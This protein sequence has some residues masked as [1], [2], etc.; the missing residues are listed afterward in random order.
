MVSSD[1]VANLALIFLP[2]AVLLTFLA[3]VCFSKSKINEELLTA[4]EEPQKKV[5]RKKK[6]SNKE[7]KEENKVVEK[8][9]PKNIHKIVPEGK[10]AFCK[11]C[12]VYMKDDEQLTSHSNGKKHLKNCKNQES[13]WF[14]ITDHVSEDEVEV[15]PEELEQEEGWTL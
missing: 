12:E 2:L 5:K 9:K 10:Y 1:E 3:F 11:Y 15:K 14:N 13:K 4:N 7:K 8:K 6:K